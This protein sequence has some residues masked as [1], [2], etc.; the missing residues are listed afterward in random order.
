MAPYQLVERGR[1]EMDVQD[2][3]TYYIHEGV[4]RIAQRFL[5]KVREAYIALAGNPFLGSVYSTRHRQLQSVRQ[6]KIKTFRNHVIYYQ[7]LETAG[8]VR[9]LRV[10]HGARDS[11][12]LFT[13]DDLT[14]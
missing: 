4:P 2:I 5:V 13:D 7:V 8:I 14:G 10:L 3:L 1:A 12:L 9:I 11:E 6:W